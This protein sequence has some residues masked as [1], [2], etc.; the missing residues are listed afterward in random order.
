MKINNDTAIYMSF[1]LKPGN[2]GARVYNAFFEMLSLNAIYI[3]RKAL[4][5][6]EVVEIIRNLELKGA[7]LSMPLKQ[8]IIPFLD[9]MTPEAV[10][11]NSVN[12]IVNHSGKLVGHNSDAWGFF[13]VIENLSFKTVCIHGAGGVVPSILWA[14]KK[15][16]IDHK[17]IC[18]VTRRPEKALSFV[19]ENKI[20]ATT[21]PEFDLLINATPSGHDRN[22]K[23]VELCSKTKALIDLNPSGIPVALA[24]VAS[25][26]KIKTESGQKMFM[27]QFQKQFEI[28]HGV[29]IEMKDIEK[30]LK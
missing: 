10:E 26:M 24:E 4:S 9:T 1:A 30:V 27:N 5:P 11:I 19:M 16:G 12:T 29:V 22:D 3:P 13:K 18:I 17:N 28:Y 6:K 2:Q 7:S 15:K 25:A 8:S 21:F 23:I 14:L 20:S